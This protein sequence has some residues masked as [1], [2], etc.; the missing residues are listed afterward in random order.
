M[1]IGTHPLSQARGGTAFTYNVTYILFAAT[2][3]TV[4]KMGTGS[5]TQGASGATIYVPLYGNASSNEQTT[6]SNV[7]T[8]FR[9]AGTLRNLHVQ[10]RSNNL[11]NSLTVNSRKNS[12]N[13]NMTLSIAGGA[14]GSFE[15]TVNSDTIA[16]GD[17]VNLSNVYGTET[18]TVDKAA[19]AEFETTNSQ[20]HLITGKGD[21][22]AQTTGLTR[23]Y[24]IAGNLVAAT[25]E[26]DMAA[27]ANIAFTASLLE[28]N[29]SVNTVTATST[30][31]LRKNSADG[32]QVVSILTEQTGIVRDISNS[33]SM[34]AAD[35]HD[36]SLVTGATG[37]SLTIRKIHL[38]AD[39]TLVS[40]SYSN[41]R[42]DGTHYDGT[43][44]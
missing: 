14:T 15:D 25:A 7:S 33:D 34:V 19:S 29:I 37:T 35:T 26:S 21:G 8:T 5:Y 39:A 17:L 12:A 36:Y 44:F 38:L 31:R 13:G 4:H 41:Y 40:A 27:D 32:N 30:L 24:P 6:E 16:S 22:T 1:I 28:I 18:N 2:T 23:Y 20:F 42:Y 11:T 10:V 9:T 43:M 3:N